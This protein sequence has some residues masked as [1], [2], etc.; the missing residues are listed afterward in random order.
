MQYIEYKTFRLENPYNKPRNPRVSDLRFH[1]KHQEDIYIN[2]YQK[3]KHPGVIMHHTIEVD[4]MENNSEYFEEAL[5]MCE[6]F[7]LTRLMTFNKSF[8]PD[9]I[10]QFY[11][12]V[13]FQED[14]EVT[15]SWLING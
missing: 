13:H 6:E 4:K 7:G 11:S 1:N 15:F 2:I 10:K 14:D 12:T 8:D 3:F 5:A 9:L